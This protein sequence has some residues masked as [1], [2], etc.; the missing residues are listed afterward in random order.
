MIA[1]TRV[2]VTG[3]SGFVGRCIVARLCERPDNAVIAVS[4]TAVP[5]WP[6][7][8]YWMKTDLHVAE[9]V[10]ALGATAGKKRGVLIHAA[11]LPLIQTL[12]PLL[13]QGCFS[14]LVA[15]G[16]TSRYTKSGSSNTAEQRM[17]AEQQ[18]TEE[19]LAVACNE[20]Q[21]PW[22]LLRPTLVYD[23]SHDRNVAFIIR[24]IRRFG[25]FPMVGE[26]TGLR[27]PLHADDLAQACVDVLPIPATYGRDYNLA[28]ADTLTYHGMVASIFVAMDRDTRII[29]VPVQLLKAIVSIL[30]LV[31]HYRYL[32][33]AMI[34]RINE[35]LVFDSTAAVRDFGFRP[36][37][38]LAVAP[39][40]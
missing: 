30:R 33:T 39:R 31:P 4:R 18:A 19:A 26:G 16:T 8:V 36:R 37:R 10:T 17:V 12:L 2:F 28:G 13:R 38:F 5:D 21:I 29:R 32:N 35:D 3:A 7:P 15:I 23:G 40:K 11:P 20:A 22:T 25:F 14:R 27:Q 9:Q 1:E 6:H 34:G 24:C